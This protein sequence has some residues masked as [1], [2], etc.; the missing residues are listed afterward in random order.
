MVGTGFF[1]LALRHSL[2]LY[3]REARTLLNIGPVREGER[4]V[5]QGLPWKV[6]SLNVYCTLI[7]P[8]L[9]G[10]RLRLSLDEVATLHSRQ[11]EEREA[12]LPTQEE[13]YVLLDD[14]TFGR[15]LQQTP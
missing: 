6:T 12:W 15:V 8:A 2:P 9:S 11:Y 13:D 1:I 4:V 10:G 7:N 5:Y 3:V 14:T